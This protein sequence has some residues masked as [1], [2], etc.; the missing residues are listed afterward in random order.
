[1]QTEFQLIDKEVKVWYIFAAVIKKQ[2]DMRI[3]SIRENP[4][5]KDRA[6]DYIS[7]KWSS[8]L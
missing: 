1:M 7:G 4:E 2:Y 5:Y 3:I 6:I 8:V